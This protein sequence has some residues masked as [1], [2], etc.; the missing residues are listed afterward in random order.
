VSEPV[1]PTTAFSIDGHLWWLRWPERTAWPRTCRMVCCVIRNQSHG[2]VATS[3]TVS[4]QTDANP[5]MIGWDSRNVKGKSHWPPGW[6][7]IYARKNFVRADPVIRFCRSTT[8]L[9]EWTEAPYDPSCEP[10]ARE[11]MR[12][13]VEFGL[14]RGLSLPIHGLDGLETCFS[15]SGK[16]PELTRRTRPA[17]HLMMMYAFERLCQIVNREATD[18][19]PL[20]PRERDV[21]CWAANGKSAVETAELLAITERTVNAHA[22]A[23]ISKLGANSRTQAVVRAMKHRY[24][25]V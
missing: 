22:G 1:Y 20:T 8:S 16:S 4:C 23:A 19:N 14:I 25:R 5:L 15:V 3:R 9:F 6:F 21:L 7:E 18:A 11:V 12:R 24:I 10:H 17:L 13:A 2:Y